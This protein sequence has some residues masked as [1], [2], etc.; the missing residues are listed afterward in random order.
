MRFRKSSLLKNKHVS[1]H[2]NASN[3]EGS[4]SVDVHAL[5]LAGKEQKTDQKHSSRLDLKSKSIR[6]SKKNFET[7]SNAGGAES[8]MATPV[9]AHSRYK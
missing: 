9:F 7:I 8:I 6:G 5:A 2:S 4:E 3:I 1:R